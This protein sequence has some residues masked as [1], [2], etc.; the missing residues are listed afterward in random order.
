MQFAKD[1]FF[2]TLR[3]R[4]AALNPERTIVLDGQSRPAIVSP[5]NE[6]V[7]EV[8]PSVA[9]LEIALPVSQRNAIPEAFYLQWGAVRAPEN[10]QSSLRPLM[11]LDCRITFSSGGA[12]G[13]AGNDRGRVLNSL[14]RELLQIC[15]PPFAEKRD[16]TQSPAVDLGTRIVWTRPR[17]SVPQSQGALLQAIATL[18]VFF[19]PEMDS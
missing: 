19:T 3:D 12:S 7:T 4:L 18:I 8:D 6:A 2:V 11:A 17:F 5:E 15:T 16:H 9:G 13:G 1:T 14:T 10:F